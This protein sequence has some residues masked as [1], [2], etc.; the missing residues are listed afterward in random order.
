MAFGGTTAKKPRL[1]AHGSKVEFQIERVA[2]PQPAVF[3]G[4]IRDMERNPLPGVT[5]DVEDETSNRLLTAITDANGTFT[6]ASLTDGLYRVQV[7]LEGLKPVSITH[8]QL[9]A[10]EVT[11]VTVDL[12]MELGVTIT[13]G[14]FAAPNNGITSST[15]FTQDF[16]NKLPM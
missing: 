2:T 6:I 10:S 1:K 3:T 4:V 9:N 11:H 14:A 13:V 8:L 5:I 7:R 15:T 16:I 12:R